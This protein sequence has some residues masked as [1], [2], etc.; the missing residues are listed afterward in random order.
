MIALSSFTTNVWRG[1]LWYSNDSFHIYFNDFKTKHRYQNDAEIPAEGT[2]I[3]KYKEI[4][5]EEAYK[6]FPQEPLKQ[7]E[8]AIEAVFK[9][10]DNDRTCI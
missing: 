5:V 4:Y 3:C 1:C 6:P 8:E 2:N 9:S 10:W 7:L